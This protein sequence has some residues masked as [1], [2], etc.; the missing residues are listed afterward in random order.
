VRLLLTAPSGVLVDAP[1]RKIVAESI[2]GSFCL[3]PR[4]ADVTT[5]LVPGLLAYLGEDD[6]EVFAAV[7]HGVLVKAGDVVRVACQRGVVA[8]DLGEAET[9]VRERFDVQ[10]EREKRARS[11]LL[12]LEADILRRLGELRGGA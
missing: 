4:H 9:T 8:G 7:D 3:L 2:E 11:T 12:R 10:S 1:A 5:L 6:R